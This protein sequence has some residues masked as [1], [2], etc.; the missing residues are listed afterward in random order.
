MT[1][2]LK[3]L[4]RSCVCADS[5]GRAAAP[6]LGLSSGAL[7]QELGTL[8]LESVQG[9]GGTGFPPFNQVIQAWNAQLCQTQGA[10]DA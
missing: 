7:L 5:V 8:A 6:L 1:L 3:T 10:L 4:N 9:T 2:S